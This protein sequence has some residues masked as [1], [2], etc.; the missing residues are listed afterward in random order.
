MT[1]LPAASAASTPPAGMESGKF[2]GGVTTTTPSGV[3]GTVSHLARAKSRERAGVVA[4]EVD[5][6]GDLGVRL[7]DRLGAVQDHRADQ[8]AAAAGELG[9]ARLE[10]HGAARGDRERAPHAGCAARATVQRPVDVRR[11]RPSA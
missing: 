11:G 4:G 10:Q 9:R 7:G 5:G 1:A 8:I 3:I 6:L 2:Q